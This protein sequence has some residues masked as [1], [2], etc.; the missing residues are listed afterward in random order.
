[1]MQCAFAWPQVKA[2]YGTV[3]THNTKATCVCQ[4][5]SLSRNNTTPVFVRIHNQNRHESDRIWLSSEEVV[6]KTGEKE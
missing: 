2:W 6:W 3:H 5:L 4:S 1:M